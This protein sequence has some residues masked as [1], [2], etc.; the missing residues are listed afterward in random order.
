[1]VRLQRITLP[2]IPYHV[3]QRGNRRQPVFFEDADYREYLQLLKQQAERWGLQIWAYCLMTN[4][5]HL[6]V[7]PE[8]RCHST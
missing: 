6:I 5:V 2:G 3:T 8:F 7:I 4:H 1:M